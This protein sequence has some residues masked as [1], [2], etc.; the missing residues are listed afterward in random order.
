MPFGPETIVGLVLLWCVF[1]LGAIP[2]VL[3]RVG[4]WTR[5]GVEYRLNGRFEGTRWRFQDV[6]LRGWCGYNGRVSVGANAEGLH[7]NTI[8]IISHPPLF[9]PW[10][11][12]SVALREVKF[13]GFRVGRVEF[14]AARVPTVRIALKESLLKKIALARATAS[15]NTYAKPD[16]VWNSSSEQP[17]VPP[18]PP[19]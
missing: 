17:I 7:L 2:F 8:F 5:L 11:D 6:T 9:I 3:G 15:L 12:L 16:A 19:Q 4:G 13:L 18:E 1:F 10:A 14:A